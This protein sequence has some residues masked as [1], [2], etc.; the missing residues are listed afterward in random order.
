VV[1]SRYLRRVIEAV[2]VVSRRY[3]RP[4]A[5]VLLVGTAVLSGCASGGSP[6]RTADLFRASAETTCSMASRE[7]ATLPKLSAARSTAEHVRRG[8]EILA[9]VQRARA[10]LG[11]LSAPTD[12][13]P[14][15]M[16]ALAAMDAL[17]AA[18]NRGLAAASGDDPYVSIDQVRDDDVSRAALVKSL[19]ALGLPECEAVGAQVVVP[20]H[21]KP[22]VTKGGASTFVADV[23]AATAA[24]G[25]YGDVVNRAG[26]PTGLAAAAPVLQTS[27]D[28]FG[29]KINSMRG[30]ALDDPTLNGQRARIV[31]GGLP[32]GELMRDV[33]TTAAAGDLT[34]LAKAARRFETAAG[35]FAQTTTR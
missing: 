9:A 2:A 32:L 10:A 3:L 4:V 21:G 15:F 5:A 25:E 20:S 19:M 29:E 7:I 16:A 13:E 18:A 34:Q 27:A 17:H 11:T 23:R 8:R 28:A 35:Y 22:V 33:A 14:D 24:L 31:S 6:E 26:G 12:L 1:A 30:Y